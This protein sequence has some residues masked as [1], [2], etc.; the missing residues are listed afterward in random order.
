MRIWEN[1]TACELICLKRS[2]HLGDIGVDD[3]MRYRRNLKK[4]GAM[5]GTGLAAGS[6][7]YGDE[8]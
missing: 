8:F 4:Y 7:E 2:D 5:Y 3:R 6:R 1:Q